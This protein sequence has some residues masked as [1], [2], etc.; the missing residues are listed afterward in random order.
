MKLIQPLLI[1]C[2]ALTTGLLARAPANKI[3]DARDCGAACDGTTDD[4]WAIQAAVRDASIVWIPA[5][6]KWDVSKVTIPAHC[7][8]IDTSYGPHPRIWS[9]HPD[10][11]LDIVGKSPNGNA[12]YLVL[13]NTETNPAKS[14]AP[15]LVARYGRPT[16][17]GFPGEPHNLWQFAFGNFG[18]ARPGVNAD[19]M[20]LYAWQSESPDRQR[21]RL[22]LGQN[23]SAIWNPTGYFA[24]GYDPLVCQDRDA[25]A[26]YA[27]STANG[28]TARLLV[29]ANR[30]GGAVGVDLECGSHAWRIQAHEATGTLQILSGHTVIFELDRE[31]NLKLKGKVH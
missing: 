3:V 27:P 9:G 5:G 17:P 14:H 22:I 24:E 2:L 4:T 11:E 23:G 30:P 7:T 20:V 6:C 31:G 13:S 16:T 21:P 19:D 8:L 12:G 15:G 18:N 29:K 25:V 28:S 26:V 1:A 10:G